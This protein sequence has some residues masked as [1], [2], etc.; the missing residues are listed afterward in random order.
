MVCAQ[1]VERRARYLSSFN[2]DDKTRQIFSYCFIQ[3]TPLP[4]SL[5]TRA[6][7]VVINNNSKHFLTWRKNLFKDF[8]THIN[9][10]CDFISVSR[11]VAFDA[12]ICILHIVTCCSLRIFST[13]NVM[14]SINKSGLLCKR[15]SFLF[16]S[17]LGIDRPFLK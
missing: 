7:N 13:G 8:P 5:P 4:K 9:S 16:S 14:I 11:A 15:I 3:D 12:T 6:P 1:N 10:V 17:F 2:Q